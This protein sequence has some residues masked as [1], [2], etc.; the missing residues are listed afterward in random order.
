MGFGLATGTTDVIDGAVVGRSARGPVVWLESDGFFTA[1][2]QGTREYLAWA[3]N[4][5]VSPHRPW[6][7]INSLVLV[8]FTLEFFRLVHSALV[9]RMRGPWLY[10]VRCRGFQSGQLRL[11]PDFPQSVIGY[12][13]ENT[14]AASSDD[15][16]RSFVDEDESLPGQNAAKALRFVCQLFGLPPSA[17]PF[18]DESAEV[19]EWAIREA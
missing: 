3:V 17:I 1:A 2:V 12:W 7:L 11:A 10:G 5:R 14:K 6:K 19:S 15:W 4:D 9:P 16:W 13:E 8:E 18:T